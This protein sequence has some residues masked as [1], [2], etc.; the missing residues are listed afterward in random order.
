MYDI[1]ETERLILRPYEVSDAEAMYEYAKNPNVGPHAGWKPHESVE[2][3][4]E[5]IKRLFLPVGAYAIIHKEDGKLIGSI[6]LEYDKRRPDA[7]SKEIGYSLAEEYWGRGFMTEAARAV[8][9]YG[10]EKLNLEVIAICTG[11]K[12]ARSARVIDKCGFVYEGTERSCYRIYDGR[13][14]DSRCYSMLREEWEAR[15]KEGK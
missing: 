3:T 5:I 2:E 15:R 9:D 10:F 14:R 11:T 7:A 1:I 8:I 12:N 13:L 4:V 6:A